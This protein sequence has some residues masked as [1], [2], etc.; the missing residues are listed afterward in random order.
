LHEGR[1]GSYQIRVV[2][3]GIPYCLDHICPRNRSCVVQILFWS[4]LHVMPCLLL[5]N[6]L[7]SEVCIC[8]CWLRTSFTANNNAWK[9]RSLFRIS[10]CAVSSTSIVV[11]VPYILLDS[12]CAIFDVVPNEM[13]CT[14]MANITRCVTTEWINSVLLDITL[15]TMS[16]IVLVVNTL[17]CILFCEIKHMHKP[18]PNILLRNEHYNKFNNWHSSYNDPTTIFVS[19]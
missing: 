19:I 9:M 3:I 18:S 2:S 17:P 14:V 15:S 10:C 12:W 16:L 13:T 11:S 6:C 8:C 1:H 4:P 7:I 5:V